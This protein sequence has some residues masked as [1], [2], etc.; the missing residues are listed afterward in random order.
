MSDWLKLTS[1]PVITS[2]EQSLWHGEEYK[3][4]IYER[5]S[6]HFLPQPPTNQY[7]I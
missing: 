1:S 5:V 4:M 7:E 6:L 3:E 2:T